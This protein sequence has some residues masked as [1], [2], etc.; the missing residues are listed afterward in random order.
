MCIQIY[1]G[2]LYQEINNF[3]LY[4]CTVLVF[5]EIASTVN[6][7]FT[8]TLKYVL[9]KITPVSKKPKKSNK[10]PLVTFGLYK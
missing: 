3:S 10:I 2:Y 4:T 9:R 8:C 6:L 5:Y 7:D 1:I